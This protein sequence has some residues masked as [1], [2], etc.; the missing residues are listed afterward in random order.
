MASLICPDCG[1]SM[2]SQWTWAQAAVSTL[3]AAP[4]LPDMATQVRCNECGH[5]GAASDLRFTAAGHF[6]PPRLLLWLVAAAFLVWALLRL[7]LQ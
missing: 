3:I 1:V 6:K 2:P 4:A 5:V 7:L